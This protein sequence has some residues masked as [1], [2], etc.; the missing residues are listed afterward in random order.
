MKKIFRKIYVEFH[1]IK[2]SLLLINKP[3]IGATVFYKGI[4]CRLIQGRNN[5]FWDL[6]P[7]TKENLK[8]AKRDVYYSVHFSEFKMKPLRKRFF[9]SFN[10]T[11]GF[12]K[13]YWYEIDMR[14]SGP[15]S[16]LRKAKRNS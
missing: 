9:F 16:F 2:L 7:T 11:Y 12:L 14:K 1:Y 6:M 13:G 15:I 10:S 5:P 8:K 3:K 4:R